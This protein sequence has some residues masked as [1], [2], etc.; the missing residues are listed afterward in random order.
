VALLGSRA[1][2]AAQG[3]IRAVRT[4]EAPKLDGRG[5]DPVWQRA[6]A[7][8][9]F[10]EQ[11]P[12]EGA[13]PPAG[14]GTEVRVLYDDRTLFILVVCHDPDPAQIRRQLGRRD[15]PLV[16]DLIELGIDSTH[17]RRSGYYFGVNA[18]GVLRDGLFFGDVNLADTWDGVWD[19]AVALR[20][21]GW[22]AE[23]AIPPTS[24]ASRAETQDW[25]FLVRRASTGRTR[26][27]TQPDSRSAN[28]LVSKFGTL[29]GLDG[30]PSAMLQVTPTSPAGSAPSPVHRPAYP[31]PG[32]P[33][34]RRTSGPT[35]GQA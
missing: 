22:S 6:P 32:S 31:S 3:P 7:F 8:T 30:C 15:T 35:S 33:S 14:W 21:D 9:D 18:A 10:L 25:G 20:P 23:L 27:S 4:P 34:P 26:S 28:G 5:D 24:S 1:S 29:T 13:R 19:A 2:E 16:G 17:D 12:S 11:F